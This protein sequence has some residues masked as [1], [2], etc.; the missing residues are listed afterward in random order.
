MLTGLKTQDLFNYFR[1]RM[2]S[3]NQTN[4]IPICHNNNVYNK[5]QN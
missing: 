1:I 2:N 4:V 5:C 3:T